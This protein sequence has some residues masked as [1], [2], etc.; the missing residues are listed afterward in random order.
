MN[1]IY[2]S[3]GRFGAK[4]LKGLL[5]RGIRPGL[6]F[7]L[8]D[9]RQGRGLQYCPVPVKSL[10]EEEDL[11]IK[12][13]PLREEE[14]DLFLRYDIILSCDLG[15]IF[16]SWI[17]ERYPCYNLHPSLLP[18]W[19]GPAPIFWAIRSGDK[20]TGVSL[21]KME[22]MVDSGMVALQE[23]VEI[24]ADW[25]Y[26]QLELVL[27]DKGVELVSR[28]FKIYPDISLVPQEGEITYARKVRKDDLRIR[29]DR[30]PEVVHNLIR[31]SSPYWGAWGM[32]G[33]KRIKF[34]ASEIVLGIDL[35][36]GEIKMGRKDLI[37]GCQGGGI[38]PLEVQLEGKR[39][40]KLEEFLSGYRNFLSTARRVE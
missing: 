9:R 1:F 20:E 24:K 35:S 39:R 8:S 31:A 18:R 25:N 10:A 22:K 11:M 29:W 37:I 26:E 30:H 15:F 19:R 40:M 32:I 5:S 17:V 12:F 6:V 28:F 27:V 38:R 23:R 3:S 33:G 14:V 21:F 34:F 2:F 7:T 36:P 16:P 4:V 13:L